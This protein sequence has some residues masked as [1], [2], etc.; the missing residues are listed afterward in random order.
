MTRLALAGWL[1]L[2]ATAHAQD[3][4]EEGDEVAAQ[5][6]ADAP[7]DEVVPPVE[8]AP[9]EDVVTLRDGRTLRG[10]V[11][12]Y[13]PEGRVVITTASG[14]TLEL[15]A[16]EVRAVEL[17]TVDRPAAPPALDDEP[18]PVRVR[19]VAHPPLELHL[20]VGAYALA[21]GQPGSFDVLPWRFRA[22]C[23]TP[24]EATVPAGAQLFGV[25]R[26]AGDS[27]QPAARRLAFDDGAEVHVRFDDREDA[28]IGG[29]I[30]LIVGPLLGLVAAV[31]GLAMGEEPLVASG[32]LGAVVAASVALPFVFWEDGV[33]L[34][35]R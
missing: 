8:R 29:L 5:P 30:A 11:E 31:I 26:A 7:A 19:F 35:A 4:A 28:R 14:E 3:L 22:L 18:P 27:P 23:R 34:T 10:L 16:D 32:V 20:E 24:C 2:A 33:E 21:A 15:A 9:F 13:E 6:V 25:S 17:A 12:R 1:A